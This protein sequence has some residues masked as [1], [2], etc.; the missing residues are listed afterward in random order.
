MHDQTTEFHY[1]QVIQLQEDLTKTVFK[2]QQLNS[3]HEELKSSE[4]KAREDLAQLRVKYRRASEELLE[5][6]NARV[7]AENDKQSLVRKWNEEVT[8]KQREVEELLARNQPP[9]DLEVLKLEVQSELEKH[10][11]DAIFRVEAERDKCQVRDCPS[12]GTR[13]SR[14]SV[15]PCP[16]VR[17]RCLMCKSVH[18]QAFFDARRELKLKITQFEQYEIDQGQIMQ[19]MHDRHQFEIG[20]LKSAIKVSQLSALIDSRS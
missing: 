19:R 13:R 11:Q 4:G 12:E 5:E 3:E 15:D 7:Q 18:Q 10:Y 6:A 2:Y 1:A 16:D 20:R 9:R 8:I 17:L 14:E